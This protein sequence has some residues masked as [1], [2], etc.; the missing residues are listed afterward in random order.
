M[1]NLEQRRLEAGYTQLGLA[2]AS[3]VSRDTIRRIEEGRAKRINKLTIY[4]LKKVLG[5]LSEEH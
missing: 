5:D 2:K 1:F 4:R 3:G